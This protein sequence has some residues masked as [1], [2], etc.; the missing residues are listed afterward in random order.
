MDNRLNGE[1]QIWADGYS[2]MEVTETLLMA[3]GIRSESGQTTETRME[4]TETVAKIAQ[5]EAAGAE[6][7]R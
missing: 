3:L 4:R 5:D 2:F 1:T 6:L 7:D